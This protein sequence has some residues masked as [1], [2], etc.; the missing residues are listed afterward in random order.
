MSFADLE[1][2]LH[3]QQLQAAI[4]FSKIFSVFDTFVK[5]INEQKKEIEELRGALGAEIGQLRG[6]LKSE[7]TSTKEELRDAL[8]DAGNVT[9]DLFSACQSDISVLTYLPL[10]FHPV[11]DSYGDNYSSREQ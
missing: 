8:I 6:E 11:S 4:D 3:L 7:I 9:K 1:N 2:G 5:V 10:F